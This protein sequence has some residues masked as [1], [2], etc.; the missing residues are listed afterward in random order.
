MEK[1]KKQFKDA[2]I[3]IW[4]ESSL[5]D[6]KNNYYYMESDLKCRLYF[7]I[8]KKLKENFFIKNNLRL[9]S[10]YHIPKIGGY[11]DLALV[12]ISDESDWKIL[13]I[14]ELKNK[15]LNKKTQESIEADYKKMKKYNKKFIEVD[16]FMVSVNNNVDEKTQGDSWTKFF[17]GKWDGK[18]FV[19]L[20]LDRSGEQIKQSVYDWNY[21]N[22]SDKIFNY[23]K[24]HKGICDDCLSDLTD[25]EPRQQVNQIC[26]KHDF[27]TREKSI[28]CQ[29]E[30][31]KTINNLVYL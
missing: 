19:E 4:E 26:N 22:N 6:Y 1:L 17:K 7:K 31:T 28:C 12:N 10:E 2:L 27:I 30:K 16:L 29:C 11:A 15:N 14:I 5:D 21:K 24:L 25:I 8:V 3:E 20:I 13:S 9:F 23:V 18:R